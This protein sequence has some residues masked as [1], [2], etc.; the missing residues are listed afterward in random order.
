[1]IDVVVRLTIGMR[2]TH[3]H[4]E[5]QD[6]MAAAPEYHLRL[7]LPPSSS[8]ST[9]NST[10]APQQQRSLCL[11]SAGDV[12][13]S[14]AALAMAPDARSAA[15]MINSLVDG[16]DS[17]G[18]GGGAEED[19][20]NTHTAFAQLQRCGW[21]GVHALSLR[22]LLCGHR[23]TTTQLDGGL[24]VAAWRALTPLQLLEAAQSQQQQQQ[25]V[26]QGGSSE[27]GAAIA[28]AAA[29][30]ERLR[31]A[32]DARS[33]RVV[34]PTART[35]DFLTGSPAQR[36]QAR[37]VLWGSCMRHTRFASYTSSTAARALLHLVSCLFGVHCTRVIIVF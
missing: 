29:L 34:A 25:G 21:A 20:N 19:D 13:L 2:F 36:L 17:S 9:S 22:A 11:P 23:G 37:C 12:P 30:A 18:G 33:I 3:R 28:A 24:D 5:V 35:S 32:S 10:P 15:A 27:A 4:A 31:A 26:H 6:L 8:T 1:M 7:A 16:G 14:L